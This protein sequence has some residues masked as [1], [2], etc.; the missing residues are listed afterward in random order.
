LVVA[1]L[2]DD[3][4]Q[5]LIKNIWCHQPSFSYFEESEQEDEEQPE[6]REQPNEADEQKRRT[7]AQTAC[8][9]GTLK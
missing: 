8:S 4:D 5:Q 9:S 2:H 1:S 3:L 7:R 6:Q